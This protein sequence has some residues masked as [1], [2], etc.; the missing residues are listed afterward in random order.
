MRPGGLPGRGGCKR[1]SHRLR[2][3]PPHEES[4]NVRRAM[5]K[6]CRLHPNVKPDERR[7]RR[8]ASQQLRQVRKIDCSTCGSPLWWH[9]GLGSVKLALHF[10]AVVG[11]YL[12]FS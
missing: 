8:A 11:T 6:P 12:E 3:H 2:P 10:H 5:P 9:F 7:I 4:L 1:Y